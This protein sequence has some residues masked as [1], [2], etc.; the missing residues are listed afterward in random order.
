MTVNSKIAKANYNDIRNKVISVLGSGSA[1]FGYGQLV[2]S[3]AVDE[4]K[5]ITVNEWGNLYFDIVNCYIHQ[6][7]APPPS[8]SSAVVNTI[9]KSDNDNSVFNAAISGTTLIVYQ[10]SAATSMLAIGQTLT[11]GGGTGRSIIASINNLPITITSFTS[12]TSSLGSFLVTYAITTQPVALPFGNNASVT[13]SGNSNSNYNGTV[14]ITSSTTTSI[15][16]RYASDPGT[17]GTGATTVTVTPN[18]PWGYS[19]WT[20]SGSGN[21]SYSAMTAANSTTQ[22][23]YLQ[24]DTFANTVVTN[25]FTVAESQRFTTTKGST[26]QIWPGSLGTFWNSKVACTVSVEFTS[27]TQARYFFNSGGEIRFNSARSGG[28]NSDQNNAWTS[29]LTAAGTRRFG[30]ALPGTGVDPNNGQNFYRLSSTYQVWSESI[31]SSPYTSNRW[32][33]SARTPVVADN[34]TGTARLVEFLIEWEDGYVDP[35]VSNSGG[36]ANVASM[37]PPGDEVDG[38][39]TLAVTTL[40]ASGI[41]LPTGAGLFSVESPIVTYGA[42]SASSL[43]PPPVYSAIPRE[44]S[45]NEGSSVIFDIFTDQFV[46][47]NLFVRLIGSYEGA[48]TVATVP[49]ASRV[50]TYTVNIPADLTTEGPESLQLEVRTGS[51]SGTLVSISSAVTVNDTSQTPLIVTIVGGGGGGGGQFWDGI[52]Y[53][54][55]GGGGGS[56]GVLSTTLAVTSGQ[57]ISVSVGT[58]GSGSGYNSFAS[59]TSG[60]NSS[61]GSNVATGGGGGG[62]GFPSGGGGAGGSPNGVAGTKGGDFGFVGG[63]G[64]NNGSGYGTGGAGGGNSA[65][66]PGQAGFVQIR[67]PGNQVLAAVSG[68][69]FTSSFNGV[70]TIYSI[71]AGSGSITV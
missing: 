17:Y 5:K 57:V 46:S 26:S 58:G 70:D 50:G 68:L 12:K 21:V 47:G 13:I 39:L 10:Q 48:G 31:A 4:T 28:K 22:H 41:L 64:G 3:T 14:P 9:I 36:S 15:T 40:E 35:P 8:P 44:S 69:T 54:G 61:V 63:P 49:I 18:N 42:F 43:S 6:T 16:V 27:A 30:G 32:K 60:G 66:S 29:L 71:T 45:V 34:S 19:T 53:A 59:G 20:L 62:L 25:R 1:D 56:G 38:T 23:P 7:G 67:I 24:Y 51:Q 2:R 37:F 65:G 55:G 11:S 33:I 52:Q